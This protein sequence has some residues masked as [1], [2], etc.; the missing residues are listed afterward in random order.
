MTISMRVMGQN[1][2]SGHAVKRHYSIVSR[3][4]QEP[5]RIPGIV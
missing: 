1:E 3:R 4:N 5:P 2:S